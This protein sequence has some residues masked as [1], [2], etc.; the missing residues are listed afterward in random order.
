M[1][2][3]PPLLATYLGSSQPPRRKQK[4][5]TRI[6]AI[7]KIVLKSGIAFLT[8]YGLIHLVINSTRPNIDGTRRSPEC[9]ASDP[10][11][12]RGSDLTP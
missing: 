8:T 4:M 10:T 1:H 12:L 2:R 3:Q 5:T 11:A 6:A 9:E 7:S